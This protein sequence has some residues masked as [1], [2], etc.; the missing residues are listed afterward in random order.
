MEVATDRVCRGTTRIVKRLQNTVGAVMCPGV[1]TSHLYAGL[2]PPWT[3]A[4]HAAH[5]E[6][7]ELPHSW[8]LTAVIVLPSSLALGEPL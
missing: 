4:V 2:L 6:S 7:P 3:A 1:L 8:A 5:V